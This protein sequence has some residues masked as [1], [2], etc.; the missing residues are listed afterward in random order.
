MLPREAVEWPS[1]EW[2]GHPG[3][4][5]AILG[6]IQKLSGHS[7]GQLALLEQGLGLGNLKRSLPTSTLL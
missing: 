5:V 1:W 6:V 4:G 2:S 7:P 3:S